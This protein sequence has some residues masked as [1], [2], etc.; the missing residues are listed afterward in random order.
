MFG[1]AE[2]EGYWEW[3]WCFGGGLCVG[4]ARVVMELENDDCYLRKRMV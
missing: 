3:W 2:G 1:G 4:S